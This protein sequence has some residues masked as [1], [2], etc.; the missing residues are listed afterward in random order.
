[1]QYLENI[2]RDVFRNIYKRDM[3]STSVNRDQQ[4]S[5][6]NLDDDNRAPLT[7]PELDN[8]SIIWM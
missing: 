4:S 1:M 6:A 2:R 8:N 3:S 7:N 5:P